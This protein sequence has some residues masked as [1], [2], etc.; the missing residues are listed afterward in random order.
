[1]KKITVLMTSLFL[2]SGFVYSKENKLPEEKEVILNTINK[3]ENPINFVEQGI[4]FH[5]YPDGEFDFDTKSSFHQGRRGRSNNGIN[6]P[7][8]INNRASENFNRDD[9]IEYDDLNRVKRIENTPVYYDRL[10]RINQAGNIYI[11]YNRQ[12]FV[13]KIGGLRVYYDYQ[14]HVSNLNGYVN[15]YDYKRGYSH[16]FYYKKRFH[17]DLHVNR[18]HHSHNNFGHKGFKKHKGFNRGF[19]NRGFNNRGFRGGGRFNNRGFRGNNFRGNN[20][21]FRSF[22]RGGSRGGGFRGGRGGFRGRRF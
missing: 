9:Y 22:N 20:N 12:G 7:G 5:V 6:A 11:N 13:S 15:P 2:V 14:G 1:M 8:A 16:S 21:G 17:N 19:N 10:G 4:E 3:R 18:G